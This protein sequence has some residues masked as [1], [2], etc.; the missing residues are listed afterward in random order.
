MKWVTA[1]GWLPAEST[2]SQICFGVEMVS[3]DDAEATFR[4]TAFSI[5]GKS[6][7]GSDRAAPVGDAKRE[8]PAGIR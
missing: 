3:T 8:A 5:D 1:K 6:K 7:P 2:L 4:V